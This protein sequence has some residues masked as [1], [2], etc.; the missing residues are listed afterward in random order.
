MPRVG[1]EAC[2]ERIKVA[3]G[4]SRACIR[5]KSYMEVAEAL[6]KG[7]RVFGGELWLLDAAVGAK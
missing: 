7:F 3:L 4:V 5:E 1:E 6:A 2:L